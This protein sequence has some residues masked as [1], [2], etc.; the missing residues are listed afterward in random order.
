M[1]TEHLLARTFSVLLCL[2]RARL[3]TFFDTHA[4]ATQV[5]QAQVTLVLTMFV[6]RCPTAHPK[7]PV[8]NDVSF[9]TSPHS[10]NLLLIL[11]HTATD[12]THYKFADWDQESL[13]VRLRWRDGLATWEIH[14]LA[15]VSSPKP[16][17]TSA[18]STH[19]STTHQEG[20]ASTLRMFSPPKSQ[21]TRTSTVFISKRQPAVA[22]NSNHNM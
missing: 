10:H 20:T 19:R 1:K 5:C 21:P 16:A 17:S 9:Q 22:H 3:S 2:A 15:Q 6:V 7:H 11:L 14:S 8:I 12:N 18:V 4:C 13:P